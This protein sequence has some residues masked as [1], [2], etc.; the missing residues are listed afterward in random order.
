MAG[1]QQVKVNRDLEFLGYA[2]QSPNIKGNPMYEKVFFTDH[3][4][5]DAE[6]SDWVETTQGITIAYSTILG[7]AMKMTPGG[8]D[9]NDCGEI[10]HAVIW[11]ASK[12]CVMEARIKV[13][14][15]TN[16]AMNVGW[17]DARHNVNNQI[18]FEITSG[19]A[20]MVASRAT[21]GA[22]FVFD[23]Q[24]SVDVWYC[25]AY[26]GGTPGTP[27]AATGASTTYALADDTYAN[28]RVALNSDGDATFYYNGEAVGFLNECL[29]HASTDLL[30]PYVAYM[31]RTTGTDVFSIDRITMWQDE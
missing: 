4:I 30:T 6:E 7:G 15:D 26:T 31:K 2:N 9:A 29:A 17:V 20:T 28:L 16:C 1:F 21:E 23:T 27:V 3:F 14:V 25:G 10:T 12:N 24:G 18:N 22:A 8:S 19:A 11:G 13:G 5:A